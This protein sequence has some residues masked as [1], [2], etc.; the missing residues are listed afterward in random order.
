MERSNIEGNLILEIKKR[1]SVTTQEAAEALEM[2]KMG[3][4]KHLLRLENSGLVGRRIVKKSVGRPVHSF[5]LTDRG[6]QYF[7]SADSLVLANLLEF[8]KER[9][10]EELVTDFLRER[11]ERLVHEYADLFSGKSLEERVSLLCKLRTKEGY[12]AELRRSGKGFELLEYSCPIF[13]VAS[14]FGVACQME[15]E[16]FS[17]TLGARVENSHRQVDGSSVCRFHLKPGTN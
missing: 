5:Y 3:A 12:M 7:G 13:K 11:Y 8:L 10:A 2:S 15:A 1:G 9:G 6:K 14:T 4:Y 16:L 17:R